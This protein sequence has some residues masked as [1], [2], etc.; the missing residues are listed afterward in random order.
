MVGDKK[1]SVSH[2][3]R[4]TYSHPVDPNVTAVHIIYTEKP[5]QNEESYHIR[6]LTSVICSE[7]AAREALRQQPLRHFISEVFDGL[8]PVQSAQRMVRMRRMGDKELFTSFMLLRLFDVAFKQV[9]SFWCIIKCFEI[10][11]FRVNG[12][13]GKLE[14]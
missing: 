1:S 8:L 6:T 7:E 14:A 3:V 4:K 11:V 9:E 2:A 5:Q 13:E 10:E 12:I